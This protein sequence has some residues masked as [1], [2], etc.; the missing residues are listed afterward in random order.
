VVTNSAGYTL[1]LQPHRDYA[2]EMLKILGDV[3]GISSETITERLKSAADSYEPIKIKSNL[4]TE[5]I[6]AIEERRKDLNGVAVEL[7]P[8]RKY[9]FNELAVHLL[10]YT[11]EVSEYDITKGRFK[12]L[13]QGSV[14][15]KSGLEETY[16]KYLRGTDGKRNDEVDA[17][18]R[19]VK[20]LG[21]VA[22]KP[23]KDL[24][25]TID[26]DLQQALEKAVDEQ[27]ASL[28]S[29]GIAPY[30]KACAV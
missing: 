10:G 23:G 6:T 5:E 19:V 27:L 14:V 22:P 12:G 17:S 25:L 7:E 26:L 3:L 2:P 13:P 18:G 20:K 9:I 11:G 24:V 15:G 4:T 16:D 8:E 30:A 29:S 21:S 1:T 28:Q